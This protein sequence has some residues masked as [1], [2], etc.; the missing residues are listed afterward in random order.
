IYSSPFCGDGFPPWTI[1]DPEPGPP[2]H[3]CESWYMK[4]FT[5]PGVIESFDRFWA[6]EDGIQTAF[7]EMWSVVAKRFAGSPGVTGFEI[8]NEP[9][10]GS[11]SNF[12]AWKKEVL[13]PFYSE[14]TEIIHS[15]APDALVFYDGIPVDA[16]IPEKTYY[17]PEGE[18]LVFAPH[19]YD[20][21]L[22]MGLEWAGTDPMPVLEK[23]AAFRDKESVP[24]LLGEFGIHPGVEGGME[25]LDLFMDAVDELRFSATIWEYSL[26]EE[27]WNHEDFSITNPDGTARESLEVYVRPWLRAVAGTG[28][29]FSWDPDTG[30]AD[31][32]W[33]AG[34]GVTEIAVPS[35][36]FPA[37]PKGLVVEG[38]GVCH[39]WD[40]ERGELRVSAPKGA[41][42]H[43]TFK[44]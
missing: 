1:K 21:D 19:Y 15:S 33:T 12:D 26:S 23:F 9:G 8:I 39:T 34:T 2:L 42:V 20:S 7:K 43:V 35:F 17:R 6:D 14:L 36:L 31:A 4:Y 41:H 30:G 22:F 27:L 16:V 28:S 13:I 38:E 18:N 37:G 29:S 44:K 32:A 25:W 10:W 3:D 11:A 24:V 5:D 40:P